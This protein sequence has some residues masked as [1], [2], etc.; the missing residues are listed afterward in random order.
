MKK[1]VMLEVTL[2]DAAAHTNQRT[3]R[4][5]VV[6]SQALV[7]KVELLDDAFSHQKVAPL[8]LSAVRKASMLMHET[9]RAAKGA[10]LVSPDLGV[11]GVCTNAS[12]W[13]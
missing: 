11:D 13:D 7:A 1:T 8:E 10:I 3:V 9:K 5:V 2:V 4:I 12:G 6:G